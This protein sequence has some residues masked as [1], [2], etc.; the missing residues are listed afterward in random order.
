MKVAIFHSTVCVEGLRRYPQDEKYHLHW[1]QMETE[2]L[3]L[4]MA[5]AC[6]ENFLFFKN[7]PLKYK[8]PLKEW[9]TF[10]N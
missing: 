2:A 3:L 7:L 8:D 1:S 6:L 9:Q 5:P 10:I 4:G